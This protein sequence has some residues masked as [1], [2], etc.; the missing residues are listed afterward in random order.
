M[1]WGLVGLIIA[2]AFAAQLWAPRPI[3]AWAMPVASV[4]FVLGTLLAMVLAWRERTALPD[5]IA[6]VSRRH[7][8]IASAVQAAGEQRVDAAGQF[9]FLQRRVVRDVLLHAAAHDWAKAPRREARLAFVGHGVA[10]IA[11]LGLAVL[12]LERHRPLG[13]TR[14]GAHAFA[15]L[16]ITPGHAEVERGSTVVIAARFGS[17]IPA[18]VTLVTQQTDEPPQRTRM[19]RSLSDPL[20][21]TT[22][23]NVSADLSYE[24][25]F[26]DERA[27]PYRLTVYDRPNLVRADAA[28]DYPDYTGWPDRRI[29]DTRR[30]SAVTGTKVQYEFTVN[31]PLARA[32]LRRPDGT[33]L[34]LEPMDT[35]GT[36]FRH[37][38]VLSASERWLLELEDRAGRT[39]AAPIELRVEATENRAPELKLTFPRGDQRVSPLEE[40]ALQAEAR[41][42]F[43]LQDYG[44]GYSVGTT[45]PRYVSLAAVEAT[46]TSEAT[47]SQLLRLEELQAEPDQLVTWFAWAD[48]HGPDGAIRRTSSDLLFAEVR[49]LEEQFREDAT[50]GGNP[51]GGNAGAAGD[52]LIEIQREISIALWKLRQRGLGAQDYPETVSTVLSSQ[53][54]AQQQLSALLPRLEEARL[55]AAANEAHKFMTGAAENLTV[56]LSAPSDH[57]LEQA[58]SQAQGAYQALLRMQ[59]RDTR[60]AQSRGPAGASSG[61]RSQNQLNELDF[62]SANDRYETESQAQAPPTPEEREQ[63]QVLAR[64]KEL[65][66]RQQDLNER[67]QEMQTAL[68]AAEDDE[69]REEIRRELKRLE[70]EQRQMLAELD[71]ARQRVDR[72]QPGQR[73]EETRE[74]L[75]RTRE[76]MRR[77]GEQLAEGEV[78]QA[79]AAGTRARENL[80][81]TSE[82][83]RRD[84]AGRF[85][86]QMREARRE[87]REL[88]AD[89]Q[90]TRTE[91]E[92]LAQQGQALDDQTQRDALANRLEA[93]QQRREQLLDTLRE[94]TESSET[95]EP[96]L[97][98]QLYDLI[99]QQEGSPT[100]SQ[101]SGASELLRRGFIEPAREPVGEATQQFEQL[102]QAVERAANAVL[103]DETSELRFAQRELDEL[104]RELERER[105]TSPGDEGE[106]S[107]GAS[108]AG[109]GR[110]A[111]EPGG[112]GAGQLAGANRSGPARARGSGG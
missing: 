10:V 55:R 52:E 95:S 28:L 29:A 3:A 32:A 47:F 21:A 89:Q 78:S 86:E 96:Q 60:V 4:A 38:F 39:N 2:I 111:G 92:Q 72:L 51:A 71:E 13:A 59:P 64:L 83:L 103:G 35:S 23:N 31:Q 80:Q 62:R 26:G 104:T 14:A 25:H 56:A 100:D 54:H 22:L 65:A 45:A 73:T 9:H 17:S 18:E 70:D 34:R 67:L 82:S 85:G 30:L 107:A 61:R 87:A 46:P 99:R 108:P 42:D 97:H 33:A 16:E 110:P 12:V 81:Q 79:L 91:L 7:P 53:Q 8:D 105:G 36:R 44:L 41:D 66:R 77:A 43:G 50:G 27:G 101:L 5:A 20:F 88:A 1:V 102:Q 112:D 63:L 15:D 75:D 11:A 40:M 106:P 58:W 109:S 57:S 94:I 49:A 48:D 74:Q 90:A 84:A 24:V 98:R 6:E 19:A 68:A 93:Q 69:Q 37:D 76:D